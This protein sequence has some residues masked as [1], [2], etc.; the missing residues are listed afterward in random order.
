MGCTQSSA[1]EEAPAASAP[2]VEKTV[3]EKPAAVEKPADAPKKEAP[4][5]QVFAIMRNGH[6]VIRGAQ[7][8]LAVLL[9]NGDL[10]GATDLW[11]KHDKWM[12]VHMTM[13]EG[14]EGGPK[15]IFK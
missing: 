12:F 7:R 6:E 4:R 1:T 5:P 13:E 9:E 14:K 3:A 10:D 11:E 15:G 2:V 8:D